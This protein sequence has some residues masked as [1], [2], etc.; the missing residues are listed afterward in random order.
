MIRIWPLVFFLVI[1][2]SYA[3]ILKVEIDGIIDPITSEFIQTSVATA[4]EEKA[5][6]LLIRLATPGGLGISMQEIVQTILNSKVPVVCFV[7][8]KGAH[9]ASAGFFILLSADV[10]AMARFQLDLTRR[11][12]HVLDQLVGRKKPLGTFKSLVMNP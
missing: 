5:E 6:F 4:E 10:A 1:S 7:S 2:S 12:E 3:E 9:A 8:P 11:R